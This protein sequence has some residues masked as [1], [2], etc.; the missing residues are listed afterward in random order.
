MKRTSLLLTA[1]L[2]TALGFAQTPLGRLEIHPLSPELHVYTTYMDLDGTPFPANG[3]YLVTREGVALLD[4]PWD[5][6][7]CF[8]LLDSIERRHG[9]PVRWSISTHFHEDRTGSVNLLRERG[10]A[11]FGTTQTLGLCVERGKP[12][13]QY[14]F[15]RDTTFD[16]GG[17]RVEAFWP[18]AAH[19]P[20]NIVLWLPR[21][22][23]LVGGCM[24]KSREAAG[25]GNLGDADVAHWAAAIQAVQARYPKARIVIPGHQAWGGK[26]ALAH[27]LRLIRIHQK[28]N[29]K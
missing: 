11:T 14:T 8:P 9:Q 7:M 24:V 22:R 1:L 6:T 23:V 16:F 21:Y 19:S 5:T 12:Q 4:T 25:L 26:A 27:T 2:W 17:T 18:G 20:D 15:L 10:V 3:L 28:Q 13:P 29:L